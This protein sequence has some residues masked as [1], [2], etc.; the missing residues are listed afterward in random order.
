M[1]KLL[2]PLLAIKTKTG[3]SI[4]TIVV[5]TLFSTWALFE[6]TKAEVVVA[7]DGEEQTVKTHIETVGELLDELGINVGKYDE[8]SHAIN[9]KIKDG[10]E[11]NLATAHKITLI[12]DG[13]KEDYITT[14][15][16]VG[17]F[18]KE[19]EQVITLSEHDEV[20]HSG[21]ENINGNMEIAITTAFPV[22]VI[23]GTEDSQQFWATDGTVKDLLDKN[24][25]SIGKLDKVEPELDEELEKDMKIVITH[26]EKKK[27]EVE[28]SIS[29]GTE[30]RNDSS[31]E[32]GKSYT[33]SEGT[34]GKVL[35]TYEV[36]YENGKE[37]DR[38]VV[39]EEVL[40]ES[41]NKIV[42]IGTKTVKKAA[43]KTEPASSGK[44]FTMEATAYGPDCNG[45]S[46]VTA[47]GINI[48]KDPTPKVISVDPSVIPLGTRVWVEGYGEAIAGDTGGAIKG[49]RIDVLVPSEAYAASNWGRRTVTVKVLD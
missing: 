23:D 45:C 10:M 41:S 8:L 42:A 49:N 27:E 14:A 36:I 30:E 46:G 37:V 24:E 44:T 9:E 31:L 18:F 34:E 16:T 2:K 20:S 12:I 17:E 43:P 40:Q 33:I 25:I 21:I 11:I 1:Q 15:E 32:K 22:E 26:V 38:E 35:K 7:A 19:I 29:F 13:E 6:A 3:Y 4:F 28:E 48:K 5:V 39:S 47:Y